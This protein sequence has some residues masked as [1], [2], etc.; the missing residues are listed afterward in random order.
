MV[1]QHA[2]E[3]LEAQPLRRR[4]RPAGRRGGGAVLG[5]AGG[6]EVANI[7]QGPLQR[8]AVHGVDDF[9]PCR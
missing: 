3:P 1:A 7:L 9:I 6:V 5:E 8:V 4:V 2:G